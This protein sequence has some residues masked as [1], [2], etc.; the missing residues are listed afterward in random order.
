M[1]PV[2][3]LIDEASHYINWWGQSLH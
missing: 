1:R 2:I 3:T